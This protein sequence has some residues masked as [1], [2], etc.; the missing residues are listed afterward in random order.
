MNGSVLGHVS[1]DKSWC[2]FGDW[3]AFILNT[4]CYQNDGS[5]WQNIDG[6]ASILRKRIMIPFN[7]SEI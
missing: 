4:L 3:A 1:P 2:L 7:Q 6:L 5:E